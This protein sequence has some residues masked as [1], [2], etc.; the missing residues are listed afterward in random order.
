MIHD[1]EEDGEIK[2]F[3]LLMVQKSHSQPPGMVLK[4]CKQWDILPFL[5]PVCRISMAGPRTMLRT[6]TFAFGSSKGSWRGKFLPMAA[7]TK[8]KQRFLM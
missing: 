6:A 4:P 3:I 5:Q 7:N 1:D 8:K 2:P